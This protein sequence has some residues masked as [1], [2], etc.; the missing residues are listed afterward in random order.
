VGS[1]TGTQAQIRA[2]KVRAIATGYQKRVSSFPD[3]PTV[4]EFIPGFTNNGWY[5]LVAPAGTPAP[6]VAKLNAEMKHALA[7]A[8]FVKQIETLGMEP[9]GSTPEELREWTRSE[10]ARWTKVVRDAGVKIQSN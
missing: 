8:E 1:V 6:I 5:G 10:I 9:I 4:S 7:N 2:G 3:V